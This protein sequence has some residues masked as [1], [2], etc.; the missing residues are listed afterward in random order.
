LNRITA[1]VALKLGGA[2][3]KEIAFCLWWHISSIPTYLGKC[4]QQVGNI[5]Q[6]TLAGAYRTSL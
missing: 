2:S 1:A 6:T 3:D 4:F 5:V